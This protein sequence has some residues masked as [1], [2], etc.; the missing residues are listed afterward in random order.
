M[1]YDIQYIS[2]VKA[3]KITLHCTLYNVKENETFDKESRIQTVSNFINIKPVMIF[4][5]L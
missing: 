1:K 2:K 3:I 4:I 5:A